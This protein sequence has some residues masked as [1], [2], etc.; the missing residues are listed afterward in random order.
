MSS[1]KQKGAVV[2][3]SQSASVDALAGIAA[4]ASQAQLVH[5]IEQRIGIE[6]RIASQRAGIGNASARAQQ[7][8]LG[9]PRRRH[10]MERHIARLG[11]LAASHVHLCARFVHF[12]VHEL[13]PI[14]YEPLRKQVAH[15][16]LGKAVR[17]SLAYR[18]RCFVE[19]YPDGTLLCFGRRRLD[20]RQVLH[21]GHGSLLSFVV[22]TRTGP[23]PAA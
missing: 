18:N 6:D 23:T 12:D 8:R 7:R 14:E 2:S 10:A 17:A 3:G 1:R 16:K 19:E 13:I 15:R 11:A 21:N 5:L 22:R 4:R 20:T 9:A